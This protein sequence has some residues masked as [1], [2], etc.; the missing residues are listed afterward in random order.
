MDIFHRDEIAGLLYTA[1]DNLCIGGGTKAQ[2]I[3]NKLNGVPTSIPKY[4]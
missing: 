1:E 2:L 3:M 4:D